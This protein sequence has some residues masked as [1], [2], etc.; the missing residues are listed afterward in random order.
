MLGTVGDDAPA[1]APDSAYTVWRRARGALDRLGRSRAALQ[2]TRTGIFR[3]PIDKEG[4]GPFVL[5]LPREVTTDEVATG[6]ASPTSHSDTQQ[7]L[8]S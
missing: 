1:L 8:H 7:G 6:R 4:C 3:P 5:G 2:L